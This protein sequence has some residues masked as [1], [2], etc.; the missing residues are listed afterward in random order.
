M[1][2]APTGLH[3]LLAELKRRRVFRVAVAY[4]VAFALLHAADIV[5]PALGLPPWTMTLVVVLAFLGFPAAVALGWAFDITAGGIVRTADA[6]AAEA[7]PATR[8]RTWVRPALA[9]VVVPF[10]VAG[11]SLPRLSA[12]RDARPG[13]G[14]ADG[15]NR[16]AR[17]GSPLADIGLAPQRG[18]RRRGPVAGRGAAAGEVARRGGLVLGEVIS[19]PGQV[20]LSASLSDVASGRTDGPVSVEGPPE[21]LPDT[22]RP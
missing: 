12:R 8:R 13:R 2:N 17:R 4:V 15:R 20:V 1:G 7:R 3:G 16:P 11:R 19:L 5:F 18:S 21:S 6:D 9:L 22:P 14:Q 10:R